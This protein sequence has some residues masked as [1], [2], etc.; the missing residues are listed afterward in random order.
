MSSA[1]GYVLTLKMT[2]RSSEKTEREKIFVDRPEDSSSGPRTHK[3][4]GKNQLM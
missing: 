1:E 3:V 2:S 4:E